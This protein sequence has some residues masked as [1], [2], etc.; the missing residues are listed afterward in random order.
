MQTGIA[1][2]S[3][4]GNSHEIFEQAI[5]QL[6]EFHQGAPDNF[7]EGIKLEATLKTPTPPAFNKGKVK[8]SSPER[9]SK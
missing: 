2:G 9:S 8:I 7:L 6:L 4:L 3:N 5:Q 1:L